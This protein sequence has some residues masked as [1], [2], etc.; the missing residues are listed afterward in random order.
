M[1]GHCHD[2]FAVFWSK[3]LRYLT[4]NVFADMKLLLEHREE[5]IKGFLQGRT[6]Y[7]QFLATSLKYTRRT[8]FFQVAIHF[9]PSHPQPNIIYTSF[10]ALVG[11]LLTKLNHYFKNSTD[12][13]MFLAIQSESKIGDIALHSQQLRF[14]SPFSPRSLPR[15]DGGKK[16]ESL[17]IRLHSLNQTMAVSKVLW[18]TCDCSNDS[19]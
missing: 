19:E 13:N 9:H 4:K 7:D 5:N 11:L 10:C 1:K 15:E 12:S 2:D 16:R 14:Q 17:G 8:K 6:N 3:L 18:L